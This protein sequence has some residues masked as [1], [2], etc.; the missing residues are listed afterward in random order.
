NGG[1]GADLIHG[2]D[3]DDDLLGGEGNDSLYGD[4]G[5]DSLT[6]GDGD[7]FLD[8]GAGNDTAL[9]RDA[10][11]AV[12]VDLRITAAQATGGAGSDTL[13]GIENLEGSAYA[14]HLTGSTSGNILTGGDGNDVLDGR[15]GPDKLYGGDGADTFVFQPGAGGDRI[16]DF[17]PGV[18][19]IDFTACGFT[20]FADVQAAMGPSN[21]GDATIAFGGVGFVQ[22][23]GVSVASLTAS[24]FIL[25]GSGG[26]SAPR[27][28]FEEAQDS[29]IG[30]ARIEL[31]HD[32]EALPGRI[33]LAGD[34]G[35][36]FG[37]LL[38]A[39]L[40]SAATLDGLPGDE[41][42]AVHTGWIDWHAAA[43][44]QLMI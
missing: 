34:D 44:D 17:V 29:V 27:V 36:G 30:A 35:D 6:G 5:I 31:A 37:R 26:S 23:I 22:I 20:S 33:Q 32:R 21:E 28:R 19:K 13:T 15:G 39:G 2:M 25:A 14:D 9:Y 24:D 11:S 40:F 18:D 12:T 3:G 38:D 7:D 16:F 42:V 43:Y 41:G 4:A 10:A 8:G 1:E